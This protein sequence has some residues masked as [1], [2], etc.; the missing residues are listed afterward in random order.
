MERAP[1]FPFFARGPRVAVLVAALV[2]AGCGD[3]S[4]EPT[5]SGGAGGHAGN[6]GPGG[7]GGAVGHGGASGGG[8]AGT[9]GSGGTGGAA[10]TSGTGGDA[11]TSAN[12]GASGGAGT[13]ASGGAAGTNPTTD[14]GSDASDADQ[15][16][17][18]SD[19][20]V[21]AGNRGAACT[22]ASECSSNFCV[23]GVCCE[24]ACSGACMACTNAKTNAT[25]GLCR[26]IKA[27][28]DPDDECPAQ[29]A[30]SCGMDGVCDG[31]GACHMWATGTVCGA[32]SCSGSTHTP[33]RTCN[34]AGTCQTVTTAS[35]GPYVCGATACKSQC[36]SGTDC[37]T[38]NSCVNGYCV[39][40]QQPGA[41][42]AAASDCASGYCVDGVCCSTTCTS[43]CMA[44]SQ[45]K[46]GQPSGTCA[47]VAAGTDPDNECAADATSCGHNGMC[48]GAGACGLSPAG[49]VCAA[50]AC[51]AGTE[52]PAR[53]CD[54]AGIC[55][56]VT[57]GSCGAFMCGATACKT[58][59]T[60]STDCVTG[61]F[62]SAGSCV[63]QEANG[64]A[65]AASSDCASGFC[66]DGVCC[67][68]ACT[69]SCQTC[70]AVGSVGVCSAAAAGTDP[71]SDCDA[72]TAS[73]CG[74]DGMCDGAGACRK[75][76][77]GTV[78][79]GASCTSG[80]LTAAATCDGAG[81][82]T[83][84][85]Q[86][87]CNGYQCDPIGTSCLA[88]C[89]TDASCTG[90]CSAATC[91]AAPTNLAGNGDVEQGTAT[92]WTSNGGSPSAASGT[93]LANTGTYSLKVA[94]RTQNYQGPSYPIPTGPGKY[95]ITA[96]AMQ[97]DDASLPV[98]LQ[99]ALNCGVGATSQ[100]FFPGVGFTT[101]QQGLWT[102]ITGTVDT[103]T[104]A[105][106]QPT[107]ATPGVVTSATLYLNQNTST[108]P[109]P[110]AFPNLFM[111]DLVIQATD[112]HNLVGNPN[113]EAGATDGWQNNGGGT[114]SVSTTVHNTGTSSLALT[115]RTQ[116][117]NGPRW[118]LPI[119]PGKYNVSL[120]AQH[121]GAL[122]HP[123][124]I[125]PT[126][127]CKGGSG[128]YP[129]AAA[130]VA[131]TVGGTWYAMSGTVTF[132]PANAPAGCK[133]TAAGIYVQQGDNG[134]CG[135]DIECPDLFIDDV[136]ITLA[137]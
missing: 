27:G 6:G 16:D 66:V 97:N 33:A 132:P 22:Q 15:G 116:N 80:T 117:Y 126:Y 85:V 31:T 73:T 26:P 78:C 76:A 41:A 57:T 14:G 101:L 36:T 83:P 136:S 84:G 5:A 49:T 118:N 87:S 42:C 65:C 77:A 92:G 50:G 93:G 125:Q 115:N 105:V 59:C 102:K 82:C 20:S 95:T 135:A 75:H 130:Y 53:T 137:Q 62:C 64:T 79:Q 72:E 134:A 104:S 7:R 88:T 120:S 28:S 111:D 121:N 23:D 1:G 103:S 55:Q 123:L 39:A 19:T 91:V 17:G 106:C 69:G 10:G 127:T 56:T 9:P 47:A 90:F 4:G 58:T 67:N 86:A 129:A 63:A 46:T 113:F 34:G 110:V 128:N 35:C 44:C 68:S 100:S 96:W 24:A 25:D 12:G 21:D 11:G 54:G 40:P 99:V 60:T 112:G 52:T 98:G 38:G 2:L 30:S 74:R 109:T 94:N 81:T 70:G 51:S 119:G 107:A 48:D 8:V 122:P 45:A 43:G 124:M 114:L 61:Y 131:N 18:G 108:A 13:G 3:G 29:A 71:R 89:T 32:E 133:L 37:T